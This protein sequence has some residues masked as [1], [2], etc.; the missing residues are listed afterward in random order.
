MLVLSV[1][2]RLYTTE[3]PIS[4][5]NPIYANNPFISRTLPKLITPPR[6]ASSVK[7]HICKIE[8]LSGAESSR[9]FESLSSRSA[10]AESS[11]LAVKE[12]S[13]LGAS[14]DDPIV[15]VVGVEDAKNRKANATQLVGLPEALPFEPRYGTF[16]HTVIGLVFL[17]DIQSITAST[18]KRVRRLLKRLLTRTTLLWVASTQSPSFHLE[19][20]LH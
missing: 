16:Q 17:I 1:Y 11:K 4:S 7:K 10:A 6:T 14:R 3:G 5:N 18:M 2:Y 8:G 13:G 15:L 9:L 12:D 20:S 19:H